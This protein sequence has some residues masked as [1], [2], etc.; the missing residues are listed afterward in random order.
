MKRN[1][2]NA[3]SLVFGSNQSEELPL[4]EATIQDLIGM[5]TSVPVIKIARR[6]VLAMTL[7]EPFTF[8]IPALGLESRGDMEKIISAF[9][10][11][12]LRKVYDWIKLLGICPYYFEKTKGPKGHKIPVIP[13]MGLGYI[14]VVVN[15]DH[16]LEYKWYWSH[17]THTE[18]E[19]KML[20]IVTEDKPNEKGQIKSPL[21][22]LLPTYRSMLKL[23]KAQDIAC[24]QAARPVHI[25]EFT[26]NARTA[27]N[28]DLTHMV[29]DFGKAAG[30]TKARRDQMRNQEIR[31]KTAELY[32]QLQH[33][34]DNNTVRATVQPTMWSDT[35]EQMLEEMDAGFSNRVVALRPDF[36]YKSAAMPSLVASFREAEDAFNIL[37][38]AQMDFSMEVLQPAGAARA[39][40]VEGA[41]Q[42]INGR[43]QEN[44]SFFKTVIQAALT[45]AYYDDFKETMEAARSWKLEN[46]GGDPSTVTCLYPELD[47][48][49]E[50]A[51]ASASSYAEFKEMWLDGL[52][53]QK[54][55]GTHA[56][57]SKNLPLDQLVGLPF[58]DGIAK[59]RILKPEPSMPDKS[60]KSKSKKKKTKS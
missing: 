20:W 44:A 56:F 30:I 31:V 51:S 9:W 45:I 52:M 37:A 18:Q 60:L 14:T 21:A 13:E 8:S 33:V 3:Q 54:T 25:M 43:V 24:T 11:P 53:T 10:M 7:S 34:H 59:E 58:P 41:T 26:P 2:A 40:N 47:V 32:K 36:H 12:W 1:R 17:G 27:I 49:V 4:D 42:F 28:D 39:Q 16:K 5:Q 6:T 48:V 29:A 57:N 19:T 22:S 23:Q 15:K 35:N 46:L 50:F 38:A 55:F